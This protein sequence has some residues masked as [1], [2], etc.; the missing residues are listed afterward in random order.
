MIVGAID[1]GSNA[2]RL[3]IVDVSNYKTGET[4]YTKINLVRVP[5]RLGLDV[6]EN[7]LIGAQ[8]QLQLLET[9]KSYRH[10]MNAYSVK[11]FKAYATSALR[12]ATNQT[13]ILKAVK[14]GCGINIEVL[15]GQQEAEL[16]W[17][18]QDVRI[19]PKNIPLLLIDVGGGSTEITIL[20][21][22][23]RVFQKS[24]NIGT[25]RILKDQ[26]QKDDWEELKNTLRKETTKFAKLEAIGTGGNIN[27]V[28]SMSKT[29]YGKPLL[30]ENLMSYFKTLGALSVK[31]RVHFYKLKEDRADVIVP[32]LQIYTSI[33][34]WSGITKIH[35]PQIGLA[36]GIIKQIYSEHYES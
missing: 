5:L 7:G 12:D 24:F 26:V 23:E 18:A 19:M 21:K 16:L 2:A 22:G 17:S 9:L 8:K 3:L 34:K 31:D 25:I 29:K 32:A 11:N 4:D 20:Q 28:F 15:S 27:K 36:D 33:M 1:I 30:M 35:V 10:L 14:S 13:D 6:F